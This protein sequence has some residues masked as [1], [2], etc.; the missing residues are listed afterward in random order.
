MHSRGKR[1]PIITVCKEIINRVCKIAGCARSD[2]NSRDYEAR[3]GEMADMG[4]ETRQ[5]IVF[6]RGVDRY[7][8]IYY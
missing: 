2:A 8:P 7:Y 6:G 3:M 4:G 1:I 5:D